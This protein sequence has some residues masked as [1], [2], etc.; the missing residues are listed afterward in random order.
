MRILVCFCLSMAWLGAV[1]ARA[2][3]VRR[4]LDLQADEKKFIK[5]FDTFMGE[6][7]GTA[8]KDQWPSSDGQ[9]TEAFGLTQKVFISDMILQSCIAS[10]VYLRQKGTTTS[11]TTRTET[12]VARLL[13]MLKTKRTTD[14]PMMT[15]ME[16][17]N[18]PLIMLE[19]AEN[20][21]RNL[22]YTIFELRRLNKKLAAE[23]Q[24]QSTTPMM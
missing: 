17:Q 6:A 14:A 4:T 18:D 11:T 1:E 19:D 23:G 9:Q 7:E 15:D 10:G 5:E 13:D 24:Q 22:C 12:L 2:R 8:S 21:F 16:W 20:L 3:T